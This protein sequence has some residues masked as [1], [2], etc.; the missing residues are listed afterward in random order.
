MFFNT[1]HCFSII[2]SNAG[3]LFTAARAV[4]STSLWSRRERTDRGPCPSDG[5]N[6]EHK[7][8][9]ILEIVS[10]QFWFSSSVSWRLTSKSVQYVVITL[11]RCLLL[12]HHHLWQFCNY[13]AVFFHF[14]PIVTLFPWSL[15]SVDHFSVNLCLETLNNYAQTRIFS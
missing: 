15:S 2:A 8:P 14:Q 6:M 12:P 7:R 1:R 5:V 13:Y 4:S 11:W 3:P 9:S 10:D